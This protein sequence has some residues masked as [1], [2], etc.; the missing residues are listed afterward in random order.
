MSCLSEPGHPTVEMSGVAALRAG[1]TAGLR[2]C[3]AE[4]DAPPC[5]APVVNRRGSGLRSSLVLR[6]RNPNDA[7]FHVPCAFMQ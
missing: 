4:S 5:L 6:L 1:R 2:R 7:P 3:D